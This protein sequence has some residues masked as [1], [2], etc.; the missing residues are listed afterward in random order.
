MRLSVWFVSGYANIVCE[1]EEP[2]HLRGLNSIIPC[3]NMSRPIVSN[4]WN[5][6]FTAALNDRATLLFS[7]WVS[8]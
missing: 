4:W 6:G 7:R 5:C 3:D 8:E 2:T 1:W